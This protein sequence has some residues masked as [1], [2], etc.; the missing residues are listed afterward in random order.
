MRLR[1]RVAI[2]T[3][4]ASGI[5]RA[6]AQRFAREGAAV[7][8]ADINRSGGG[9]CAEEIMAS[10]GNA[11]FIE[12]DVSEEGDL[13]RMVEAAVETYGGLDIL[14]NNAFWN[15][16][17]GSAGCHGSG[18]AAYLSGYLDRRLAGVEVGDPSSA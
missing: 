8:I 9:A 11:I 12:T 3:G 16:P 4:A 14:H 1:D 10:G 17:G 6:T 5:G 13:R 15:A 2:I 7:V 18:L